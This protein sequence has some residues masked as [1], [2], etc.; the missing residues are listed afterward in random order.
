MTAL[1]YR[2]DPAPGNVSKRLPCRTAAS[3][4]RELARHRRAEIRLQEIIAQ[5]ASL[6]RQKDELI[7][8]QAL[9][10]RESAH[11]L[12]ND[13][14]LVVSML[15][16]QSRAAANT[17]VAAQL[18]AA[19]DRI[20]MIGRI[21][22]HLHSLDAARTVAFKRFIEELISDF[23]MMLSSGRV[24]AVEGI[25]IEL[26]A[27]TGIALGFV[28]NELITN[29]AKYGKGR[30]AVRLERN[31]ENGY[32]LSVADDGPGLP[33]GF[34]PAVCKGLGMRIVQGLVERIGG[35]LR[36]DRGENGQGARF[37]VLFARP[38]QS[39]SARIAL[40]SSPRRN[41][42]EGEKELTKA[43]NNLGDLPCR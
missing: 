6:L 3:Y 15:S 24:I 17:E 30:I 5:D 13:L 2:S 16:L 43:P 36:V 29:A 32:A 31:G 21:H 9:L 39:P 1:A 27:A 10:I 37:T 25:D 4:E 11:R 35:E 40:L 8:N 19:A 42:R 28:V 41:E 14:Q 18:A 20:V 12:L 22:R 23:S 38:P 7:R 34:D 33:A 26:P